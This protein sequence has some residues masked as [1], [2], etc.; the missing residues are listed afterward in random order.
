MAL[1]SQ[2]P[3]FFRRIPFYTLQSYHNYK[4]P[5][6]RIDTLSRITLHICNI[7]FLNFI[8]QCIFIWSCIS[9]RNTMFC[10][11]LSVSNNFS[12]KFLKEGKREASYFVSSKN[13]RLFQFLV[14]NQFSLKILLLFLKNI[15]G[16]LASTKNK[17]PCV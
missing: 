12:L 13:M 11:N 16:R 3:I 14:F 15:C 5:V 9:L 1:K 10:I 4:N 17:E 8:S 7:I 6:G 2:N